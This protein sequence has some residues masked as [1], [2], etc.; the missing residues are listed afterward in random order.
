VAISDDEDAAPKGKITIGAPT[1]V[2]SCK[3]TT[4]AL[5][6]A[7]FGACTAIENLANYCGRPLEVDAE[8]CCSS[9][10]GTVSTICTPSCNDKEITATLTLTKSLCDIKFKASEEVALTK[11]DCGSDDQF[12]KIKVEI[13][14]SGADGEY[15]IT[16]SGSFCSCCSGGKG[17]PDGVE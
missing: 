16:V 10:G 3:F 11:S 15:E 9:L 6:F 14:K 7:A 5:G 4:P 17:E 8:G 12:V 1:A 13:E 2:R